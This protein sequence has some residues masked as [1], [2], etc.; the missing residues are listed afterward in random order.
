ML[1]ID[2]SPR[3]NLKAS[4]TFDLPEPLGPTMAVVLEAKSRTVFFANDLNPAISSRFN[5]QKVYRAATYI[6]ARFSP[7]HLVKGALGG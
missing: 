5:M 4:A 7:P 2:C 6:A 3:A 1:F